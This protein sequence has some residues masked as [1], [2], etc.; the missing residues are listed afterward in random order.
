MRSIRPFLVLTLLLC[1]APAVT[2]QGGNAIARLEAARTANPRSVAALRALGVAYFKAE[3]F[4]DARAVLD[5]ARTLDPRDGVSALYAGMS[6]EALNDFTGAKAAYNAYLA[7]GKTRRVREDIRARLVALARTEVIAGAR[8]AVANEATISQTPGSP[9]TIAVPPLYVTGSDELAPLSRGMAELIITDLGRSSQL[10]LVERDR[11]QALAD[12]IQLSS[13]ER[14]DPATAARAGKLLQA[15]R[16]VNGALVVAGT[17]LTVTSSVMTV[18]NSELSAPA[19][20]VDGLDNIFALQKQIVFRIFTQLG[21]T[22]TPAERQAVDRRA[23][24]NFEAFLEFSRGLVAADDGRFEDASRF[25]DNARSLDPGFGA[26]TAR[27]NAAQAAAVG[28]QISAA[29]IESGL[30]G[31]TEGETVSDAEQGLVTTSG[32]GIDNTLSRTAQDVNPPSVTAISNETTASG[33]R[34]PDDPKRDAPSSTTGTDTPAPRTGTV[35]V[36]IRRP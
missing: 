28:A 19:E 31:S 7:N 22:L 36:I 30:Q 13:S 10:T 12:E 35:T 20:V 14:A 34:P 23:T 32:A 18:A 17:R 26:A 25:F 9:T 27:F 24:A 1:A 21:V 2:A 5:H 15:G 29:V 11:M 6:A 4:A 33:P 16:V 8:A 3:R